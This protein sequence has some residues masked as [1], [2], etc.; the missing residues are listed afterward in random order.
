MEGREGSEGVAVVY[1]PM[2][3]KTCIT[4]KDAKVVLHSTDCMVS[5]TDQ[6]INR[7]DT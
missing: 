4:S 3:K 5:D 2:L 6:S 1:G 7:G